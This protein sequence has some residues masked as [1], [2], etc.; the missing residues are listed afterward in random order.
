MVA[1]IAV[2]IVKAIWPTVK[3]SSP[4][5]NVSVG[6]QEDQMMTTGKHTVADIFCNCC[7]WI[8]GWKYESAFEK[9]QKYKE[10]KFILE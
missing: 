2:A 5:V 4:R 1:S 3:I 7:Q 6:P 9:S 8:V 10:G